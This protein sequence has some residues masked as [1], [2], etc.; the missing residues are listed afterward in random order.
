MDGNLKKK[1][2]DSSKL[3]VINHQA[4]SIYNDLTQFKSNEMSDAVNNFLKYP[5]NDTT[6][7]VRGKDGQIIKQKGDELYVAQNL[8]YMYN[9]SEVNGQLSEAPF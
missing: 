8:A 1:T 4:E 5:E 3:Y 9:D 2:F 7:L 6:I